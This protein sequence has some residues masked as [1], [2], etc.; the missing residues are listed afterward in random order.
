MKIL[1][2]DDDLSVLLV[3]KLMIESLRYELILADGGVA[4]IEALHANDNINLIFLDL[5]MPD[6]TGIEVLEI[7]KANE[8]FKNI[9]VVLQTGA[10]SSD[11][12]NAAYELGIAGLLT[13]PYN[14]QDLK[15]MIE[16]FGKNQPEAVC[17]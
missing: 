5:M 4:G 2:I 9:P 11:E 6:M 12:I 17:I 13:K 1:F 3:T 10:I 8:S 16:K 7:I 15:L 14:K